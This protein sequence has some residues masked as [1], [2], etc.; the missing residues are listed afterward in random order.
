MEKGRKIYNFRCYICHGYGGDAR[1]QA[2]LVLNPSPRNFTNPDEMIDIH[3]NHMFESIKF[4]RQDTAMQ[5][6]GGILKDEEIKNLV[7]F[8]C[9][10]FIDKNEPN[11]LYHSPDN[12]WFDFQKKYPIAIRYFLFKGD[13]GNLSEE[14]KKGKSIFNST[15]VACHLTRKREEPGENLLFRRVD[16]NPK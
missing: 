12:Q 3:A 1:T 9:H 2:A 4:G 6:F 7:L 11:I 8:I 16:P 14:L 13:E 5:P 15:C 10:T